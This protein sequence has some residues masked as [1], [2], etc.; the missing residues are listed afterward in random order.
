M[1]RKLNVEK[2]EGTGKGAARKIRAAGGVPGVVYGHGGD[3][4]HITV[5]ARE[6]FH[7]LHTEAGANVLVDMR[8]DGDN[9]LAMPREVQRDHL[10]DRLLHVDF[11][12]IARD[13]KIS[14]EVPIHLLGESHGV[15]EGGVVEH[16]LWSLHIECLPQ[17]VPATVEADIAHLGIGESLKVEEL[18]IP[19]NLTVLTP[20]EEVVVSIVTPQ[21]LQVEEEIPEEEAAEAVGEAAEGAPAPEEGAG[22]EQ[23]GEAGSKS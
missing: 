12:R 10:R 1:E 18:Q 23:A 3:P 6:L 8:V 13:V 22:G 2:R 5:D 11:L 17:D 7:I 4:V 9:F 15:K 21:V 14:V 20:G 19:E 16:H